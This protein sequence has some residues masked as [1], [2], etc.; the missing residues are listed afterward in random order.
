MASAKTSG[1]VTLTQQEYDALVGKSLTLTP[2][3]RP[4]PPPGG[5]EVRRTVRRTVEVPVKQSVRVPVSR[6]VP[7]KR[8]ETRTVQSTRTVP[9]TR[10]RRVE[11]TRMETRD[12]QEKRYK[13]VWRPEKVEYFE[14]VRKSVPVTE[15]V[16]M[17]Y[18][19]YETQHVEVPVQVCATD[20]STWGAEH[21]LTLLCSRPVFDLRRSRRCPSRGCVARMAT[22]WTPC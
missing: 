1:Y 2:A 20:R 12:V 15:T 4:E 3:S 10:T 18:T 9:V 6:T 19:S 7:E 22:A 17:P 5:A 16:E 8:M 21:A 13:W 14:T 11:Q